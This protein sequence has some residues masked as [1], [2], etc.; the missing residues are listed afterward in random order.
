[1]EQ[2][3]SSPSDLSR[4]RA[5]CL[6]P[7][8]HPATPLLS[9]VNTCFA[10]LGALCSV[11]KHLQTSHPLLGLTLCHAVPFLS[12]LAMFGLES[13]ALASSQP[14]VTSD[15]FTLFL[16]FVVRVPCWSARPALAGSSILFPLCLQHWE[17]SP[18]LSRQRGV[19]SNERTEGAAQA[20]LLQV[21]TPRASGDAGV[22]DTEAVG[23]PLSLAPAPGP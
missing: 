15:A 16:G 6:R 18:E 5:G 11:H 7:G 10:C 17:E 9:S 20:H 3:P 12:L 2:S 1:M 23:W 19:F 21:E 8:L 22:S 13:S 4:L 14:P